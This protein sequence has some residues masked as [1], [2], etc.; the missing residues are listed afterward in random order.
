MREK[1][2]SERLSERQTEGRPSLNFIGQDA[3]FTP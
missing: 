2:L 3:D 1:S